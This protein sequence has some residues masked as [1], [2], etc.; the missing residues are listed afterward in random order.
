MARSKP[1][2]SGMNKTEL[3]E[4]CREIVNGFGIGEEFQSDLISDLILEKHYFCSVHKDRPDKFR[5]TARKG[6]G[7]NFEGYFQGK[8]WHR[9]SWSKSITPPKQL[10]IANEALRLEIQ[11]IIFKYK[12]THPICEKCNSNKDVEVDHVNPEFKSIVSEALSTMS[13]NDWNDAFLNFEW[14][15]SSQFRFPN[16]NPALRYT[17]KV[18]ETA[19][20]QSVC[21]A[22]HLEN[23]ESRKRT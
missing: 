4:K 14:W 6:P 8:G 7:Y 12:E 17:L 3:T 19:I 5:K 2:F 23:A 16:N 18:H 11:P 13:S 15:S 21:K 22:C 1:Y 10:T 20:L 9:V